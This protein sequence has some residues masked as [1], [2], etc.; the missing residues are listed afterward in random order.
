MLSI[1]LIPLLVGAVGLA[2]N[3]SRI[4]GMGFHVFLEVL[5]AFECFP[6]KLAAVRLQRNVNPDVGCD[7]VA[8]HDSDV[9]VA[10]STLQV[11]IVGAL[12]TDVTVADVVLDE[13]GQRCACAAG[14]ETRLT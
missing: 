12:S 8:L 5:R 10:P 6:A 7:M 3:I 4:I 14:E 1:G 13:N 11:E 2:A 9:T